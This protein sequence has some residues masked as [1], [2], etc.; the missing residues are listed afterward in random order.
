MC[1]TYMHLPIVNKTA[2]GRCHQKSKTGE[3]VVP[4]EGLMS[5]KFDRVQYYRDCCY[6]ILY[7][8]VFQLIDPCDCQCLAEYQNHPYMR[9]CCNCMKTK[10]MCGYAV[11]SGKLACK[12]CK[13]CLRCLVYSSRINY[14]VCKACGCRY[15]ATF[16][17]KGGSVCYQ[18]P[19]F[20]D[21]A[22]VTLENGQS[23]KMSELQIGDQVQTGMS[24]SHL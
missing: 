8:I 13:E 17:C 16:N 9:D 3:S 6:T 5:S 10:C 21:S 4:E 23:A 20:P 7:S 1:H 19:C 2:Q 24:I 15:Y 22:R 14:R 12:M 18:R 11:R